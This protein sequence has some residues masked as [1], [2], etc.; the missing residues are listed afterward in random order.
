[1][2]GKITKH[3]VA[4]QFNKAKHFLGHAYNHTKNILGHVDNGVK[5][6]KHVYGAISPILENYGVQS[7]DKHVMKALSGYDTIKNN[8]LEKHDKIIDDINTVKRK[9]PIKLNFS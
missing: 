7:P 9:L 6:F 2:F 1:M 8:V 5:V 3:H 4:N